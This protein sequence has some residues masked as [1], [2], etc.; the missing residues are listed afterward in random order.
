MMST[1]AITHS[2]YDPWCCNLGDCSE[3]VK[4]EEFKGKWWYTNTYGNSAPVL[5]GYT[6]ILESKDGK[7]HACVWNENNGI[8]NSFVPSYKLRCLYL[9]GG[10]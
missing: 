2:W 1:S 7:T 10:Q 3:M 9:P 5:E 6:R 8:A 4:A